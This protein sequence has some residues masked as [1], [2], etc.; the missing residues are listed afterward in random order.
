MSNR[1][2]DLG[3]K[4]PSYLPSLRDPTNGAIIWDRHAPE[5]AGK[6]YEE[7]L[8]SQH[9]AYDTYWKGKTKPPGH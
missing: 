1:I 9:A 5:H 8:A 2:L 3:D 7:L 4:P 6:T